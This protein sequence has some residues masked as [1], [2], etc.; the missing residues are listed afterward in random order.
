MNVVDLDHEGN[1]TILSIFFSVISFSLS[2]LCSLLSALSLL[3]SLLFALCSLQSA[4]CTLLSILFPLLYALCWR[5]SHL[6]SLISGLLS[7][8]C[9]SLNDEGIQVVELDRGGSP[10]YT[11]CP[12]LSYS[13]TLKTIRKLDTTGRR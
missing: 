3:S 7:A 11:Y 2:A 4:L 8:F 10:S 1:H 12:I 5:L 9:L 6:C 13:M